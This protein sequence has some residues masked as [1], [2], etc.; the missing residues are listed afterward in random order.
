ML[1]EG[2]VQPHCLKGQSFNSMLDQ[3]AILS[4][5][6]LRPALKK[7][8]LFFIEFE[9]QI[10]RGASI[11][12]TQQRYM[13]AQL[14]V[15]LAFQQGENGLLLANFLEAVQTAKIASRNTAHKLV[16][17]MVQY[18]VVTQN[19]SKVD[20]RLRPIFLSPQVR[21]SIFA[22]LMIHLASLDYFDNG[23]RCQI[24][25]NHPALLE[26]VH[27]LFVQKLFASRQAIAPE[28]TFSIFTWMNDG[29]LVMD[30][31]FTT[32]KNSTPETARFVTAIKSFAE[33]A[34][35]LLISKT[36]LSRTMKQAEEMGSLGWLGQ[37]GA[38]TLW[39]SKSFVAEYDNYQADKLEKID[40][41]FS[42]V[43][44]GNS[45]Q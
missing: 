38:S 42:E 17:E 26:R 41:A 6:Q 28:G 21:A 29:G 25:S 19:I 45:S 10:P 7:Q 11:F 23:K 30:K 5:P 2:L 43:Q 3:S 22:W 1:N 12:A 27:P 39:V 34:E 24:F 40:Q 37:R 15:A 14:A 4:H 36:H 32:I 18:K 31:I 35:F 8:A 44:L 16:L 33:L 9:Q 13:L 20:K